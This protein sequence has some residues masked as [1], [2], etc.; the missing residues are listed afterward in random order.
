MVQHARSLGLPVNLHSDGYLM[1]IV[2]DIIE[3]GYTSWHPVQESAGMNPREIK[4]KYGDKI[5][6][7]L[8]G[9][10]GGPIEISDSDRAAR[11]AALVAQAQQRREQD[12][13]DLV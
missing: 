6:T 7:E 2:D 9:A 5:T 1:Q 3:M 10:D 12:A 8:T 4:E 13:S 11:V